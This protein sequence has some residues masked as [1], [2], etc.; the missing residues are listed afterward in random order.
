V[1]RSRVGTLTTP[2]AW[3]VLASAGLTALL[4]ASHLAYEALRWAGVGYLV[5]MGLSMVWA[6][7]H[8]GG[9]SRA[10]S[11]GVLAAKST[12]EGRSNVP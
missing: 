5:W 1:T 2:L 7:R 12:T 3:G 4:T 11:V 10:A 9:Q 6:A 8:R